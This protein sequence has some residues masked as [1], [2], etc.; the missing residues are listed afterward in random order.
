MHIQ[1]IDVLSQEGQVLQREISLELDTVEVGAERFVLS[2]KSPVTVAV[3]HRSGRVLHVEAHCQVSV[4]I[5]CGRC[6]EEVERTFSAALSRDVDMKK[7]E[8]EQGLDECSFITG[9]ELDVDRMIHNEL[10]VQWPLRVLCR[11]DCRGICSRCGTNLNYH[12][13]DC[14]KQSLDPRMVAISDIFSKFKE[15]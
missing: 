10:L 12:N 2:A 14:E 8:T 6:L 3:T 11:E 5:P 4:L 7:M 1:L 9:T 15:E 13:C